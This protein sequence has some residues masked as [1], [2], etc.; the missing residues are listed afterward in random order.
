MN[1]QPQ[2]LCSILL[3]L[4]TNRYLKYIYLNLDFF[5]ASY[6]FGILTA[7]SNLY[8]LQDYILGQPDSINIILLNS[9]LFYFCVQ[10]LIKISAENILVNTN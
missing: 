8:L 2:P 5:S 4:N 10:F 6:V 1:V 9:F 3:F 7:S